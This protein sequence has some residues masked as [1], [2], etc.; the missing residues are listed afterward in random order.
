MSFSKRFMQWFG[1]C[2]G[3]AGNV[4]LV[5]GGGQKPQDKCVT[6]A[7]TQRLAVVDGLRAIAAPMVAWHHIH[8]TTM[9]LVPLLPVFANQVFDDFRV[10]VQIF[11]IVSG[12]A[13]AQSLAGITATFGTFGRFV[14]RRV[15]RLDP[16]FWLSIVLAVCVFRMADLFQHRPVEPLPTLST[17][18]ANATYTQPFVGSVLLMDIYWTLMVEFQ[19]Y[20]VF[21]F[22]TW[23][24]QWIGKRDAR[25]YFAPILAMTLW[26][27]GVRYRGW[28]LP[29]NG[30]WLLSHWHTFALGISCSYLYQK[31]WPAWSVPVMCAVAL[32][33]SGLRL[34]IADVTGICT[35]MFLWLA[36]QRG[37]QG[38]WL[39]HPC[40]QWMAG[41][42]YSLYLLHPLFGQ[43]V[44]NFFS[45]FLGGSGFV[46]VVI[47]LLSLTITIVAA[48][49]YARLVERP[50][51]I[52]AQKIPRQVSP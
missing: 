43:R 48:W 49:V 7:R 16:P 29:H 22:L 17:I 40:V 35:A 26:G 51:I 44:G 2:R 23:L 41:I 5:A 4:H 28:S 47:A 1:Q 10:G 46:P 32:V 11:F 15:I 21:F 24:G 42:S 39:A 37:A 3:G 8:A 27:W 20:L 6:A 45:R 52:L 31:K 50:A 25:F 34:K 36:L 12:F 30:F 9:G 38:R 19:F 14:V 33:V 18:I 13:I